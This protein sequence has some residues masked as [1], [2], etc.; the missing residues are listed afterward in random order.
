M[1]SMSNACELRC[2]DLF[3][4]VFPKWINHRADPVEILVYEAAFFLYRVHG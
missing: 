2:I 4:G 3:L 1:K